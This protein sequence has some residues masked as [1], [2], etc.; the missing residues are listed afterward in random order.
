MDSYSA[1][2]SAE[3]DEEI[4][5]FEISDETLEMAAGTMTEPA[6]SFPGAPTVSVLVV[7]CSVDE[8]R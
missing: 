4:L 6:I 3:N 8:R 2:S 1:S 7:C 5:P